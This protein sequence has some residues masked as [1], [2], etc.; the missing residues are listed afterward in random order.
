[1]YNSEALKIAQIIVNAGATF[2]INPLECVAVDSRKLGLC[3]A[4]L[5]SSNSKGV[6]E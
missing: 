3:V 2:E 1:M 5:I 6:W 4:A